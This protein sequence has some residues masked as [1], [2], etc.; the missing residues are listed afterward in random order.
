MDGTDVD[1]EQP[2]LDRLQTVLEDAGYTVFTACDGGA[3][4]GLARRRKPDLVLTDVV[5]P[6]RDGVALCAQ[7]VIGHQNPD[8]DAV[9][10]ALA[11]AGF[12][13]WQTGRN[14]IP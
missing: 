2:I 12:Y 9:C 1:D 5:M 13:Q 6:R 11:Y 7:L 14:A 3:A 10:S 8:T 4:L